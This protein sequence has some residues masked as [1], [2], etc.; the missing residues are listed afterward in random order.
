LKRV[1]RS[2]PLLGTFVT[3]EC[4]AP[5]TAPAAAAIDDAFACFALI[6]RLMHPTR[7]DSD[8][9]AIR[10]ARRSAAVAVHA[11][12]WEVLTLSKRLNELTEGRFD[13]CLPDA[14]GRLS[15]LELPAPGIVLRSKPLLIDLGGIA[16]GF[17]VDRA[18]DA[19]MDAGCR[20]GIVNAGGDLR[21]FGAEDRTIWIRADGGAWPVALRDRA[22]AVS[23][24]QSARHPSEHSGYYSRVTHDAPIPSEYAAVTA[25]SAAVADGMTKAVLLYDRGN[26]ELRAILASLDAATVELS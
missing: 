9:V 7:N 23:D 16:K 8:L 25:A 5:S 12:T 15:D 4:V 3:I 6:E 13:P 26:A 22:L 17:A 19:L 10:D 1:T 24:R 11:W 18:V 14:D 20:S 21:V 2:R